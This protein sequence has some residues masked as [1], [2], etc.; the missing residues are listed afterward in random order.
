MLYNYK[1]QLDEAQNEL[2]KVTKELAVA[3]T[4]T[5]PKVEL[6]AAKYRMP[7]RKTNSTS[8]K[9]H[10]HNLLRKSF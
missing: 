1:A 8:I 3:Q 9:D 5:S 7:V 6:Q 2:D 4:L 10:M